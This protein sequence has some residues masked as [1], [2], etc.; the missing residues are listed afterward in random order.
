MKKVRLGK[1]NTIV[2]QLGW[3]GIPRQRVS[4]EEAISVIREVVETGVDLLDTARAY[5]GDFLNKCSK[6]RL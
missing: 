3:G 5:T 4:E 2:T 6:V 1:T